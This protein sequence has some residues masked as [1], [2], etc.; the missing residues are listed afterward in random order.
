M[1]VELLSG[2][3]STPTATK[4]LLLIAEAQGLS[5]H[6]GQL[7]DLGSRRWCD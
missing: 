3:S 4:V 7:I 1:V 2:A 6:A 5:D